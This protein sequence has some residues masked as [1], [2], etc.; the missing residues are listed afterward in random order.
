MPN[1][2]PGSSLSTSLSKK[3]NAKQIMNQLAGA[4]IDQSITTSMSMSV[5]VEI[6][7]FMNTNK[8]NQTFSQFWSAY[9]FVISSS[10]NNSSSLFSRTR[11]IS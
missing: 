7:V 11:Y 2:L 3:E 5:D 4:K 6:A 10:C 9:R 8:A 1:V